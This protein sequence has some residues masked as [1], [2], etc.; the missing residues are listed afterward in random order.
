MSLQKS[1]TAVSRVVSAEAAA[2]VE[3]KLDYNIW[4]TPSRDSPNA[5]RLKDGAIQRMSV[6]VPDDR[7]GHVSLN[8]EGIGSYKRAELNTR[9]SPGFARNS[10]P[11][12]SQV[13][14]YKIARIYMPQKKHLHCHPAD[15]SIG[16]Y[17]AIDFPSWGH[18][19][20][21]LM[22]WGRA[23]RDT[24]SGVQI[25]FAKLSDAVAHAQIMGWG[26]DISHPKHRWFVKKNYAD[27]FAFKGDPKPVVDY[28]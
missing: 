22:G 25:R 24:Y 6:S 12:Q 26:Y 8:P 21:P 5:D 3:S 27:N 19:K 15:K 18:Y 7:I 28:D 17:W 9:A 13:Y 20:S 10:N 23:T 4:A 1:V 2:I 16:H 11:G 14:R